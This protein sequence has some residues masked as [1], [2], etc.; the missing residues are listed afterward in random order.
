MTALAA[1]EKLID[2]AKSWRNY[3]IAEGHSIEVAACAIRIKAF[4]DVKKVLSN[5]EAGE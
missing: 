1:V 3:H 5:L 2:E 4:I